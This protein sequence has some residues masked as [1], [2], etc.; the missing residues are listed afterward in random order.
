MIFGSDVFQIKTAFEFG[1]ALVPSFAACTNVH[2]Y[3][4]FFY[5]DQSEN[6]ER[7]AT[8]YTIEH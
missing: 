8:R 1:G 5:L 2:S 7:L 6:L 4:S 3:F